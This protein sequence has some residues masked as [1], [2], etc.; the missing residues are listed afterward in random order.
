QGS[1]LDSAYKNAF[2]KT[3]AQIEKQ[4]DGYLAAGTFGTTNVSGRAVNPARDFHLEQLESDEAKLVL[5]DVLLA[6]GSRDAEAAYKAL[7]GSAAAEGLGLVGLKAH[8]DQEA[9]RLD[10]KSV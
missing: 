8:Q 6:N 2:E 5:A 4:V 10:R 3:K 1:E 7:H 9:R